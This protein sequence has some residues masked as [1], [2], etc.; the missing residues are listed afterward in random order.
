VE[1]VT[2]KNVQRG[3]AGKVQELSGQFRKKQ[4]VYMQSESGCDRDRERS[5]KDG[6]TGL[7]ATGALDQEQGS[8]GCVWGY[9]AQRRRQSRRVASG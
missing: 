5:I 7:R 6:L 9:Y 8:A 4:R 3:L 2:T 1:V